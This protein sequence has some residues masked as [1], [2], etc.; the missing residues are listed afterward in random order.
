MGALLLP[1]LVSTVIG[2][3]PARMLRLL[4]GW[5]HRRAKGRAAQ[6]RQQWLRARSAPAAA[7]ADPI[8]YQLKPW[9]D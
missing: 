6:R 9:R 4:D 8:R 1:G 5:S 7:P 2:L 3:M